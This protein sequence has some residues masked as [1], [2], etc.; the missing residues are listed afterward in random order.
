M[1]LVL[2]IEK[3]SKKARF[4]TQIRGFSP[5]ESCEKVIY[6]TFSAKDIAQLAVEIDINFDILVEMLQ[7]N[8]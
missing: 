4:Y 6:E 8:M 1:S 5:R 3:L 7:K 2:D